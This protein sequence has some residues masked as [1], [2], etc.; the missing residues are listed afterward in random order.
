MGKVFVLAPDSFKE[1]M[2]AKEVCEAMEIGIKRAIPDA[3]CIHVPMADGGEGTVQSLIDATGGTL[4]KKEVTGPLGTKVV[5]GY[6]ILGDGKTAVIEMA[7]ASGIHFVTKET[8]NP[9]ITTTYG[10]GEL[11]KDCIEQG[12]TDIILGIGGSATNDG[13]TGMAAALGYKFLDED[14]KELKL[15]GGFLDRLATIDTSNV[16][17][18]LRDVHIL[19]ASDVTNPLCGEHGASRVFGPQKGATPEMVEILDNNLR[20]YA[21]VVKDQLGIDVLN[22]PG[23]GAAGGLG[24]GL[25]AFTNATMKKGIEIV[26]EYTNLKEK[27]RHADYCFTGEGG[28]DFQTK[29]GKTPY[30]VAKVAKSVNPNMKVIAL[31]GYIGKDVEVLYEEGFDAIFGIVPG[32]AELSTLLKQGSENVARTAESVARLLR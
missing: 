20:H 26:I 14:G 9:L 27:L 24:A 21:Q 16:I 28:I 1:S 12:I 6:G 29:F 5:A 13:G 3:E 23:A 15:G 19:V 32:A 17:P 11:I 2:T 30:G 10:T 22:V 18:G 8:K 7:A 4:E 31:A 25:L